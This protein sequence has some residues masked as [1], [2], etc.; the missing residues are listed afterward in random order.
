MC[1][2][3][4][5]KLLLVVDEGNVKPCALD[6]TKI[7]TDAASLNGAMV[8]IS[9]DRIIVML[10][11]TSNHCHRERYLLPI[12]N[13]ICTINKPTTTHHRQT[14]LPRVRNSLREWVVSASN[15][16]SFLSLVADLCGL[17]LYPIT[18]LEGTTVPHNF[19]SMHAQG[20]LNYLEKALRSRL[21]Q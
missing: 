19:R 15:T 14:H 8:A 11:C 5:V 6:E 9:I 4:V 3:L 12:A 1:F 13:I 16:N 7:K 2:D 10:I 17:G 21:Q 20:E 18:K